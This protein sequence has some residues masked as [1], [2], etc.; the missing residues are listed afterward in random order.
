MMNRHRST[1]LIYIL[2]FISSIPHAIWILFSI[3]PQPVKVISSGTLWIALILILRHIFLYKKKSHRLIDYLILGLLTIT[4]LQFLRFI[5]LDETEK[6]LTVLTNPTNG[7]C[8]CIPILYYIYNYSFA[9]KYIYKYGLILACISTIFLQGNYYVLYLSPIIIQYSLGIKKNRIFIYCILSLSLLFILKNTFIPDELTGDT[10]RAYIIIL[11]YAIIIFIAK[12]FKKYYRLIALCVA[13]VSIVLPISLFSYSVETQES[14]FMRINDVENE[15]IGVDTRTFLYM[16]LLTDLNQKDAFIEGLGI[17]KGYN[18]PYFNSKERDTNEVHFL[19][20]LFRGGGLWL[21]IYMIIIIYSI[22]YAIKYSK[23]Y[24]CLGG[25]IVLS[26]NFL[27][28]FICDTNG[29]NFIHVIIFF[30]ITVC[31]SNKWTQL[32]NAKILRLIK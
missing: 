23:N 14:V 27:S 24:L 26:G 1:Q 3:Y 29:F 11:S 9:L 21:F 19:H 5:F 28:G 12:L 10:Q 6:I 7:L 8:I 30:F 16:E 32:S 13:C 17:A 15:K 25:S 4:G 2:L 20:F 18:S 31:S 22:F